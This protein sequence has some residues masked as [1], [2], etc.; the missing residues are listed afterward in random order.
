MRRVVRQLQC[1]FS[2][3]NVLGTTRRTNP[4]LVN[5]GATVGKSNVFPWVAADANGHVVITWFGANLAGNSNDTTVMEQ[6]CFD[7][8]DSCWAQRN[9]YVAESACRTIAVV[10]AILSGCVS[11]T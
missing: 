6:T 2:S 11:P 10:D 1:L 8:T 7:G 5:K 9:V 3:S 4:I